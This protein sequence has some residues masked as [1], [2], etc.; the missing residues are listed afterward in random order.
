MIA[1]MVPMALGLGEGGEQSAPLGR[2][3]IGGLAVATGATLLILPAVF[4]VVMGSTK[5]GTASLHPDDADS[6]YYTPESAAGASLAHGH[7]HAP[8]PEEGIH[9]IGRPDG[10]DLPPHNLPP[11]AGPSAENP[12]P[13]DPQSPQS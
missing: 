13:I 7:G 10:H 11:H 8:A 5:I 2:A 1:G 4:T 6:P 3:V 12:P 9:E